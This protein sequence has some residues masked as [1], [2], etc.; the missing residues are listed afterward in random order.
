MF[1]HGTNRL[2]LNI[3]FD[4]SNTVNFAPSERTFKSLSAQ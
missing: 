2:F 4:D 1:I 3:D